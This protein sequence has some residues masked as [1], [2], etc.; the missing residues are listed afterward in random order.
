V[1]WAGW[2]VL[3]WLLGAL[4][5]VLVVGGAVRLRDRSEPSGPPDEVTRR[6][7]ARRMRDTPH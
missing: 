3:G 7:A 6:R 4:C 1:T 5:V 2:L